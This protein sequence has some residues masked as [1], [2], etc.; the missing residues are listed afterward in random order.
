MYE[1]GTETIEA[2]FLTIQRLERK[3]DALQ[4]QIKSLS[5]NPDHNQVEWLTLEELRMYIPSRPSEST[6]RRLVRNQTFPV[7]HSGKRLLFKKS[8]ID[9]WL[10]LSKTTSTTQSITDATDYLAQQKARRP[11]PWRQKTSLNMPVNG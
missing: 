10:Q 3:I 1:Y 8:D 2:L 9:M 11:A 6:V 7:Y 4:N 5:V